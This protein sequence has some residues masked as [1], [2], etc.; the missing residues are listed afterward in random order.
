[1]LYSILFSG[2]LKLWECSLDLFKYISCVEDTFGDMKTVI[3]LGCGHGLPGISLLRR[4]YNVVFSDF[5]CD[6]SQYVY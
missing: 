4:G 2:G 3:E 6:V 1:M 5:N